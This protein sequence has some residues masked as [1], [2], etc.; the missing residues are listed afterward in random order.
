MQKNDQ[1]RKENKQAG[2]NRPGTAVP[3]DD[4]NQNGG[5]K[6]APPGPDTKR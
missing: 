6:K 2:S 5:S 3:Y 4:R 1:G